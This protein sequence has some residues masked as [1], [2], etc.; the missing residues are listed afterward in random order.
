[1]NNYRLEILDKKGKQL[2][3]GDYV[4]GYK[5]W[6]TGDGRLLKGFPEKIRVIAKIVWDRRKGAFV[7]H[8]ICVHPDD[9]KYEAR[10]WY[11]GHEFEMLELW[12][13]K[14]MRN[15]RLEK[16]FDQKLIDYAA[17]GKFDWLH[18]LPIEES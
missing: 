6:C 10:K 18:G 3:E 4:V 17:N 14:D 13:E 12:A 1:M 16:L 2:H 7:S 5:T 15:K 9:Q 11:R 8:L